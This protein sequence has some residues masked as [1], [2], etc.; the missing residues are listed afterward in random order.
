MQSYAD[1]SVKNRKTDEDDARRKDGQQ[2]DLLQLRQSKAAMVPQAAPRPQNNTTGLPDTLKTGL[3]NLSGYPMD[4]VRVHYNSSRPAQLKAWA[5]TQGSQIHIAPGQEKYLPHEAWHVVQQKQG[6]V[7][8]TT[9]LKGIDINDDSALEKEAD[10]MGYRALRWQPGMNAAPLQAKAAE[11]RVAVIQR[12]EDKETE[13]GIWSFST[14]ELQND[15]KWLGLK[16][17]IL[18]YIPKGGSDGK[19]IALVQAV[20][21]IAGEQVII[22]AGYEARTHENGIRIDTLLESNNP[23]FGAP[24]RKNISDT[25]TEEDPYYKLGR[26]KQTGSKSRGGGKTEVHASRLDNPGLSKPNFIDYSG[27]QDAAMGQ[28]LITAALDL[29]SGKYLGSI[30]YGWEKEE[31]GEPYLISMSYTSGGISELFLDGVKQWNKIKGTIKLPEPEAAAEVKTF[32]EDE[33]EDHSDTSS[34]HSED[35]RPGLKRSEG[36]SFEDWMKDL[37]ERFAEEYAQLDTE[38]GDFDAPYAPEYEEDMASDVFYDQYI[39]DFA[40]MF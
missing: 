34:S 37:K 22:P 16:E 3:E 19:T 10:T 21:S 24:K 18:T 40:F 1:R 8:A 17:H 13:D 25:P 38:F 12:Q 20:R 31:N 15:N 7:Q 32:D 28:L 39:K 29:T 14:Y 30:A 36:V 11:Q 6:R 5:Y 4:D 9:Q 26:I 35:E 33:E 23:V 2:S 27:L